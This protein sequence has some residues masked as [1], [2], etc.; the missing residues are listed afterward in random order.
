VKEKLIQWVANTFIGF[1]SALMWFGFFGIVLGISTPVE[2][3]A[4]SGGFLGGTIASLFGFI[5][6]GVCRYLKESVE[7]EVM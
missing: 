6:E 5:V 7:E 2:Y 4:F 1:G 3:K